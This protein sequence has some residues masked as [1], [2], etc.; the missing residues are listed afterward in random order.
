MNCKKN[1]LGFTLIELLITLSIM[2]SILIISITSITGVDKRKKE[3]AYKQ[4]KNT[5]ETA[6]EQYI[7]SN[8]YLFKGTNNSKIPL[9]YLINNGFL[10]KIVDPRNGEA[11][12]ECAYVKIESSGKTFKVGEFK[13]EV[14]SDCSLDTV[15]GK[16]GSEEEKEYDEAKLSYKFLC[17]GSEVSVNTE[18]WFN[19]EALKNCTSNGN[20]SLG[21]GF[22]ITKDNRDTV[23]LLDNSNAQIGLCEGNKK[24]C[25]IPLEHVFTENTSVD[26]TSKKY[27]IQYKT[28]KI[29]SKDITAYIDIIPPKVS[30]SRGKSEK[31]FSYTLEDNN[32]GIG[33]KV[34]TNTE[35]T[36]IQWGKKYA[37]KKILKGYINGKIN[38]NKDKVVKKYLYVKDVAGNKSSANK[39][40]YKTCD[41][42]KTVDDPNAYYWEFKQHD[43][44]NENGPQNVYYFAEWD[45][46]CDIDELSQDICEYKGSTKHELELHGS[47]SNNK[48]GL[49]EITIKYRNNSNGK[50]ACKSDD[51]QFEY[52][53]QVCGDITLPQEV[54]NENG[55]T[56]IK[57]S[58][59]D[60]GY[61]WYYNGSKEPYNKFKANGWY[62]SGAWYNRDVIKKKWKRVV[63]D[64]NINRDKACKAAC[65]A[66]AGY[67]KRVSAK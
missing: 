13:N 5:I 12:N 4:V 56:E 19:Q 38:Y 39:T 54:K 11:I 32:S 8:E 44:G 49:S 23:K 35:A 48:E 63:S 24:E 47:K 7:N 55:E 15:S 41:N 67:Y 28:G 10:N 20:P 42:R 53:K 60:H 26:G 61:Q 36:P 18:G 14:S 17:N 1:N 40:Q 16:E 66:R 57:Y 51:R 52:V 30:L 50:S 65:K 9:K 6:A 31:N 22:T 59:G 64:N 2:L 27:K 46:K 25:Y 62:H 3:E 43:C 21:L 34:V 33:W 58:R 45:C 37:N 29:L